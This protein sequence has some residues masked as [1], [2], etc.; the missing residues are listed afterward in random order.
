MYHKLGEVLAE[1]VL[2]VLRTKDMMEKYQTSELIA[3]KAADRKQHNAIHNATKRM[4]GGRCISRLSG[5]GNDPDFRKKCHEL[6]LQRKLAKQEKQQQKI[7][8]KKAK[9]EK[10]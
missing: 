1:N 8:A 10:Q 4:K 6:K 9:Q 2:D 3:K 7:Q 5:S